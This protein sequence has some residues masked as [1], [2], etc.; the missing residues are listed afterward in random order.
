MLPDP[1]GDE[2][3]FRRLDNQLSGEEF[4]ALDERLCSDAAFRERFVRLADLDACLCD[5]FA[6]TVAPTVRALTEFSSDN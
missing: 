3:I 4:L 5:E 2:L 1:S 6:E